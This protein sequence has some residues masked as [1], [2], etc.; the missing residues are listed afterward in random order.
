[1]P[2]TQDFADPNFVMNYFEGL[3][4]KIEDIYQR[5]HTTDSA[6]TPCPFYKHDSHCRFKSNG[7]FS[8]C[9][10]QCTLIAR[11]PAQ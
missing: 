7:C 8:H 10:R 2:N 9:D 6:Q 11:R 3:E 5:L 4:A 1:M